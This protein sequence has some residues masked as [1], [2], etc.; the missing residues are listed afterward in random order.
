MRER[1]QKLS[2]TLEKSRRYYAMA[3]SSERKQLSSEIQKNELQQL[4]LQKDIRQLE[5][6][7]RRA[8]ISTLIH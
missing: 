6:D 5:K 1:Y 8:E 4:S 7:I 3:N 2:E